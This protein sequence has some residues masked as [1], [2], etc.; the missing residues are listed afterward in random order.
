M[1][2]KSKPKSQLIKDTAIQSSLDTSNLS[3]VGNEEV[4]KLDD[5]MKKVSRVIAGKEENTED[6]CD[7]NP[8]KMNEVKTD[9]TDTEAQA[10]QMQKI[11][12]RKRQKQRPRKK[13][14]PK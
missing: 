3:E 6:L 10:K 13:R 4:G 2:R 12:L 11:K 9:K 8:Q 1:A 7:N 5:F 14:K